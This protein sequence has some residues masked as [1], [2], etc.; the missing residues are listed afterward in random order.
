[1]NKRLK[2]ECIEKKKK[3]KT[4]NYTPQIDSDIWDDMINLR[5]KDKIT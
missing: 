4:K 1:M 2:P 3:Q 5:K